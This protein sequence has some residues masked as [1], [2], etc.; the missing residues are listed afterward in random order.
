MSIEIRVSRSPGERRVALLRDGVLAEAWVERPARPDG[1]GDVVAA[2]V[3]TLAPAMA[4]AFILMPDGS[5]GFLPES[6][7][8]RDRRPLREAVQEGQLVV[9]RVTRAAQGLKGPR[10]SVRRAP[11]LAAREPGLLERGPG[12]AQRLRAAFPDAAFLADDRL[13]PGATYTPRA[14]DDAL[15]A[16]FDA[17]ALPAAPLP[18][19]G[20]LRIETTHALTALDVDAGSAAG[21]TDR[22]AQRRLNE[23][24]ISEAARQIRLRNL[25]GAIL[26]DIAGLPAKERALLE[27]PLRAALRPDTLA[28]LLG[29]GPLGLFEIR[30]ARIHPPLAE[31]LRGPL[32]QGLALLRQAARE[33]AAT[34][35][36]RLV[37]SAP[38]ATLDALRDLPGAL[39]EFQA[40][41]GHPITLAVGEPAIHD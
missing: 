34:P 11:P 27:E 22:L 5:T 26:L 35:H 39:E 4:G 16:E 6:E 38:G 2:R 30:R 21:S 36:R 3:A 9:C 19:G 40:G 33:A 1:V 37:L 29:T 10:L 7:A 8:S 12:A 23:A 31:T 13:E 20:T 32:A 17:L 28:E 14:F 25:A 41:A 15:E 18:G 24:A